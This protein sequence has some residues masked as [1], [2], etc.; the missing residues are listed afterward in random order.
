MK[1]SND[2]YIPLIDEIKYHVFQWATDKD[3]KT[4]P[5]TINVAMTQLMNELKIYETLKSMGVSDERCKE[6]KKKDTWAFIGLFKRKYLECCD[7]VYKETMDPKIVTINIQRV[8]KDITA[9]GGRYS[10]FIEWFFDDF[11][12]LEQNKKYMPPSISLICKSFIVTKYLYEKKDELKLRKQEISQQS[13]R[14]ALIEIALPFAERIKSKE[15][16]QKIMDFSNQN[17]TITKFFDLMKA[18]AKKMNDEEAIQA[19]EKISGEVKQ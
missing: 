7:I 8:I 6:D 16:T 18:F 11:L 3:W 17:I 19:C 4:V 1:D 14:N 13:I 5:T 9:E 12:S 2:R 10:E 15:F